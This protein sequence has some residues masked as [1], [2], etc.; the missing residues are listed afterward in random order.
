MP[1]SLFFW[2][3]KLW[4]CLPQLFILWWS[5]TCMPNIAASVLLLLSPKLLTIKTRLPVHSSSSLP[6]GLNFDFHFLVFFPLTLYTYIWTWFSVLWPSV[7]SEVLG[8]HS[9]ISSVSRRA[10]T[11]ICDLRENIYR[12][13]PKLR[14]EFR[15][16][17]NEEAPKVMCFIISTWQYELNYDPNPSFTIYF[18]C[19]WRED[20]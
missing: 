20:I 3:I 11:Y 12:C 18:L 13:H 8:S 5:H 19:D 4:V 17:Y 15:Q 9:P 10:N 16:Y 6:L 2:H 1:A 14:K 7:F